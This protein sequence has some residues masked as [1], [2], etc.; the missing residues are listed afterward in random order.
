VDV[1]GEQAVLVSQ[2]DDEAMN[3]GRPA[4]KDPT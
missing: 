1:Q 4:Y 3:E 2:Y